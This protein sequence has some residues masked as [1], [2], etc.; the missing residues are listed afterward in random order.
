MKIKKVNFLIFIGLTI[1]IL[2]IPN[3]LLSIEKYNIP[4]FNNV[5]WIQD[6]ATHLNYEYFYIM[7]I[8]FLIFVFVLFSLIGDKFTK[9]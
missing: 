9:K 4:G 8:L 6:L 3:L 2:Y 1:F 7:V 5:T